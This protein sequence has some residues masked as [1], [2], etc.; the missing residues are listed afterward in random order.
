MSISKTC[1]NIQNLKT[2]GENHQLLLSC[3]TGDRICKL[4][5]LKWTSRH[6]SSASV[7][8]DF[9]ELSEV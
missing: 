9:L 4:K 6:F 1:V 3:K 7:K 5:G 2:K 8:L